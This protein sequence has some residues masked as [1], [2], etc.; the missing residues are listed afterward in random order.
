M[1]LCSASARENPLLISAKHFYRNAFMCSPFYLCTLR[2]LF[3][4]CFCTPLS[5]PSGPVCARTPF[6]VTKLIINV[7]S[8]VG[9]RGARWVFVILSHGK[10]IGIYSCGKLMTLA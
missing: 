8:H 10:V 7:N 6:S 2:S 5:R 3:L 1:T 4:F 9:S